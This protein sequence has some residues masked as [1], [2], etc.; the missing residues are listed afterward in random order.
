MRGLPPDA[1]SSLPGEIWPSHPA[2][3]RT[4]EIQAPPND[5]SIESAPPRPFSWADTGAGKSESLAPHKV[6]RH[7]LR[8]SGATPHPHRHAPETARPPSCLSQARF[9]F[10]R[11]RHSPGRLSKPPLLLC[12][13]SSFVDRVSQYGRSSYLSEPG[14][15]YQAEMESGRSAKYTSPVG[16]EHIP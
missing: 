16:R 7:V 1:I 12:Q 6:R 2:R 13:K 10:V 11:L 8:S 14:A 3:R 5:A 4:S 9:F 15:D